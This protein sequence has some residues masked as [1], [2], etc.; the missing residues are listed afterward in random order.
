MEA[1]QNSKRSEELSDSQVDGAKRRE[2]GPAEAARRK[3]SQSRDARTNLGVGKSST[4][5]TD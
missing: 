2:V 5:V 1:K 4:I 3:N